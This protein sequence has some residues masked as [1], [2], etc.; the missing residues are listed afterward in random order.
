MDIGFVTH[1]LSYLGVYVFS[2]NCFCSLFLS[3]SLSLNIVEVGVWGLGPQSFRLTGV[4]VIIE[5]VIMYYN[6]KIEGRHLTLTPSWI[7]KNPQGF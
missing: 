7:K 4:E 5:M 2:V 1:L 6:L 3:L